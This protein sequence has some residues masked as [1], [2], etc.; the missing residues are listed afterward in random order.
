MFASRS[1]LALFS[2]HSTLCPQAR[3]ILEVAQLLNQSNQRQAIEDA[4]WAQQRLDMAER[5]AKRDAENDAA[6]R[7][8][9]ILP[10]LKRN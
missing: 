6:I 3:G 2:V 10:T 5:N 4:K 9:R 7:E 1:P 8:R